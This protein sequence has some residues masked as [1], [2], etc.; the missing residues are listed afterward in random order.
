V[1]PPLEN[2]LKSASVMREARG[3]EKPSDHAPVF[4]DIDL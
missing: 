4:V 3:W 1:T 2:K